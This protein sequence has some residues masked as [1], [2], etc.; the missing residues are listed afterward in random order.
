MAR[1]SSRRH[2]QAADADALARLRAPRLADDLI[3]HRQQARQLL[4]ALRGGRVGHAWLFAGERA[5]GKATLAFAFARA[6]LRGSK[7]GSETG[8]T[9]G[10]LLG[11]QAPALAEKRGEDEPVA[12]LFAWGN[13]D[14]LKRRLAEGTEPRALVLDAAEIALA[15][16]GRASQQIRVDDVR[17][18]QHFL[19][20]REGVGTRRVVLIDD[21]DLMTTAAANALLKMLEEPPPDVVFL[22]V[23]HRLHRL[24]ATIRSRCRQLRFHPLDVADVADWLATRCPGAAPDD[25][26]AAASLAGGAPGHALRLLADGCLDHYRALLE[27]FARK[28]EEAGDFNTRSRTIETLTKLEP[29]QQSFLLELLRAL[30]GRLLRDL[31]L[32]AQE[33]TLKEGAR[34]LLAEE[35]VLRERI[36]AVPDVVE[37]LYA[38]RDELVHRLEEAERLYLDRKAV[39]WT[40]LARFDALSEA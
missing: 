34:R 38:F 35:R 11:E 9:E 27:A 15:E 33:G 23:A 17:R 6:L 21:A 31:L 1:Q 16:G 2:S 7:P 22:L 3:G 12:R 40:L 37:R 4:Q 19:A 18:I 30:P 10:S 26:M 24:P 8:T 5:L 32:D 39:L 14:G 29:A 28:E 20:M 13:E 25:R 36:G